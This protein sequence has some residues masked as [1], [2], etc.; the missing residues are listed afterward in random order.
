M[1][2]TN[3][4]ETEKS[5]LRSNELVNFIASLEKVAGDNKSLFKIQAISAPDKDKQYFSF[6]I[7]TTGYFPDFLKFIFAIE[8]IPASTY[9]LIEI[10]NLTIKRINPPTGTNTANIEVNSNFDM[11]V[12]SET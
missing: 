6:N 5:F 11:R 12:Y 9:R 10:K 8:N 4:T 2:E 1:V 3:L 7:N